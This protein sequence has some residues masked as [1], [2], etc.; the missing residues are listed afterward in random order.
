[1]SSSITL[2]G[3]PT[4]IHHVI[5]SQLSSCRDGIK[6]LRQTGRRFADTCASH[7][8]SSVHISALTRDRTRFLKVAASPHLACHVKTL[9]CEEITGDFR[10]FKPAALRTV[11]CISNEEICLHGLG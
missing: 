2:D 5:I 4:E 7:L 1:M 10:N 8:F 6:A 3:M 11:L 9:V